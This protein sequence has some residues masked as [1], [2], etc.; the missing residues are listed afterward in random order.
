LVSNCDNAQ[1]STGPK[2]EEGKAASRLN[3]MRHKVTAQVTILPDEERLAAEDFCGKLAASF[4]PEGL[5]D[6][7]LVS[8]PRDLSNSPLCQKPNAVCSR[9]AQPTRNWSTDFP[10]PLHAPPDQNTHAD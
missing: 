3:A 7:A 6:A 2:T 1:R 10:L 5:E 8:R 4:N 9:S